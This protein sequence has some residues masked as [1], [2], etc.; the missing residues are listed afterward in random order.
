MGA[1]AQYSPSQESC[2]L[3]DAWDF[4]FEWIILGDCTGIMD[5]FGEG[6]REKN[7]VVGIHMLCDESPDVPLWQLKYDYNYNSCLDSQFHASTQK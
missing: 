4:N 2:H 1:P 3:V 7:I 5:V 6:G